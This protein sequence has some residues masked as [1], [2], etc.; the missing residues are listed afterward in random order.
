MK[1]KLA[2]K[3]AYPN[4]PISDCEYRDRD[5]D[6]AKK[7]GASKGITLR[8]HY[9]GEN[10]AKVLGSLVHECVGFKN[11]VKDCEE[12]LNLA[13]KLSINAADALIAELEKGE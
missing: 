4:F 13:A 7:A 6:E 9:A 3:P 11:F 10:M 8:Q 5:A 12:L 2:D 1:E